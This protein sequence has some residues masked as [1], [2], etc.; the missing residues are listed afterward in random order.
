MGSRQDG[1][2]GFWGREWQGATRRA[3]PAVL[4]VQSCNIGV[5]PE[6]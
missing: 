4:L 6:S 5:F 2:I 3:M 1:M